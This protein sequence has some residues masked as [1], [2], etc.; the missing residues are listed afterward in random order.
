MNLADVDDDEIAE[1]VEEALAM[2][3]LGGDED[4]EDDEVR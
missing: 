4:E 1:S 2:A 3:E